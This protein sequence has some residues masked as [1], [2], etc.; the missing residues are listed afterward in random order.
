MDDHDDS[1]LRQQEQHLRATE[2][3]VPSSSKKRWRLLAHTIS[4]KRRTEGDDDLTLSVCRRFLT[5]GLMQYG[6]MAAPAASSGIWKSVTF[7]PG[8]G[9]ASFH[10]A[11]HLLSDEAVSVE[12]LV[13]FNN[14]GN[15]C[16]WPA[17]EVM[18]YYVGKY[19]K[20]CAG[21]RV[22]ELGA[23]M[24]GVAGLCAASVKAESVLLTDGNEKSV[25]NLD[26]IVRHSNFSNVS[27]RLLR[28]DAP[29]D[30]E[31]L[32]HSVDIILAADCLF[33]NEYRLPLL[34]TIVK[35]LSSNGEA[36]IFAPSR[37]GTF[38]KFADLAKLRDEL[39]IE[40]ET[41]Y[42]EVVSSGRD[43]AALLCASNGFDENLH[44]PKLIVLR[45]K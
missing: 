29:A 31:G 22:V 25:A 12:D 15:V 5:F 40:I 13:G 43:A 8:H 19:A 35:L 33:F 34:D 20:I 6:E 1:R 24:T 45:R 39:S 37:S 9:D 32:E 4:K 38:D 30:L 26:L 23:G 18:A 36:Y 42:D 3:A 21:R 11:V 28:W 7:A 41:D 44:Y 16:I 2:E 17:E 27:A 14:T 10:A